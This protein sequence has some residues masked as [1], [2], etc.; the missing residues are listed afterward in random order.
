MLN[1]CVVGTTG[2]AG[3]ALVSGVLGWGRELIR[4]LDTLLLG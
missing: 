2:W 3:R 4:G 1:V